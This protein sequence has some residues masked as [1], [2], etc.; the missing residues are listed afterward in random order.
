MATG[1]DHDE[2]DI[3]LLIDM[4]ARLGLLTV[5]KLERRIALLVGYKVDL[6]PV[7]DLI[8]PI[9]KRVLETAVPL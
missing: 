6:V 8:D 1:S 5:T 7:D 2:S 9:R 3:D 4:P